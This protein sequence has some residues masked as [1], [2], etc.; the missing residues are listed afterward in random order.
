[1][2][3]ATGQQ[4]RDSK[5][6]QSFTSRRAAL[7]LPVY[8]FAAQEQSGRNLGRKPIPPAEDTTPPLPPMN[9]ELRYP[10]AAYRI[11]QAFKLAFTKSFT[12]QLVIRKTF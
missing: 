6:L 7:L 10:G 8:V 1:M 2:L 3:T 12:V 11:L 4:R 9:T 5:N